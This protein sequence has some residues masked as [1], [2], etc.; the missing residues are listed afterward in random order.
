LKKGNLSLDGNGLLKMNFARKPELVRSE[1]DKER[2]LVKATIYP[3]FR[4]D[5]LILQMMSGF[6]HWKGISDDGK[7]TTLSGCWCW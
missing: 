2:I 3:G 6:F 1:Y 7:S 4:I 5:W